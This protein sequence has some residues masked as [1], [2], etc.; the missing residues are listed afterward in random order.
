MHPN[1]MRDSGGHGIAGRMKKGRDLALSKA[2][3]S[4]AL[5]RDWKDGRGPFQ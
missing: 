2:L 5:S 3:A 1:G 4:P